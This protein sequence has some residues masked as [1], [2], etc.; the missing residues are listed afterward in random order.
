MKAILTYW[1]FDAF[2]LGIF[3]GIC[4]LYAL[5]ITDRKNTFYFLMALALIT[6]CFFS[7]LHMLSV[8]YLFSAHMA[9]HVILLLFVGPLLL[10][11]LPT[12]GGRF[13]AFFLFLKQHPV[14]GWL[15]GVGI[16]WIW[17]IPLLFNATMT[18]AHYAGMEVV[19]A[20]ETCSLVVVGMVFSAPVI[21]PV[22]KFR[23]DTL[24]AV[25]YLF[26]ACIGCS[27]LGLL[28]TFAPAGAYHHFL[29][30]Y[31]P[32]G[33]NQIISQ[34]WGITQV[35]DQQAA[36]LIMWVPCCFIYVIAAMYLLIRWLQ[37]KEEAVET[38]VDLK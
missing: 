21:N 11:S 6:F 2:S 15:A 7:P 4:I 38:S 3:I 37:E 28:I 12:G 16:M 10:L 33:L 18:T 19:H 30:G 29:S 9:V 24:S 22:K 31:D 13:S 32:Y 26:T 23:I 35:M 14:W 1:S 34:Q 25:V 36:G 8:H 20:I 17:H 27:V 5:V